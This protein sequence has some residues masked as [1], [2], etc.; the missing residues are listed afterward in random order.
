M[1]NLKKLRDMVDS[2]IAM[3]EE[4]LTKEGL[5]E[6]YQWCTKKTDMVYEEF[7]IHPCDN[8][9]AEAIYL[10]ELTNALGRAIQLS[11]SY[12]CEAAKE[13]GF[14]ALFD[15]PEKESHLEVLL[16]NVVMPL[17]TP[18][19]E[20]DERAILENIQEVWRDLPKHYEGRYDFFEEKGD[21]YE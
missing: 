11:H 12:V 9:V 18:T 6:L 8:D 20:Y 16:D 7:K 10:V 14:Q 5:Q 19:F 2:R 4:F 13:Q 21:P 1:H 3:A 17:L 15:A